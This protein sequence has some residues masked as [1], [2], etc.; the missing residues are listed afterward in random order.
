MGLDIHDPRILPFL[1]FP[2]FDVVI[3]DDHEFRAYWDG[4]DVLKV[5]KQAETTE[6]ECSPWLY[7]TT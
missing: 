1:A 3:P 2:T 4:H 6:R 5:V 7:R